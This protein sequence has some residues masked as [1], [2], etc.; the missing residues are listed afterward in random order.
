MQFT[1]NNRLYSGISFLV[2]GIALYSSLT[3]NYGMALAGIVIYL[4]S[5]EIRNK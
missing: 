4:T 5:I 1:Q 3:D 2:L